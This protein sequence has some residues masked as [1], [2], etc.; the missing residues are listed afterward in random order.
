MFSALCCNL[1]LFADAL[2]RPE[3][4]CTAGLGG[5][6]LGAVSEDD[7]GVASWQAGRAWSVAAALRGHEQPP[8]DHRYA[9]HAVY[10]RERAS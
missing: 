8:A 4:V 6:V 2:Q 3:G 7:A 5:H 10:G 1:V 9:S